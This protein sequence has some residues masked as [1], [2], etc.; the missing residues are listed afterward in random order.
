VERRREIG[1]RVARVVP[2]PVAQGAPDW[3]YAAPEGALDRP[4]HDPVELHG[5]LV[6]GD[7]TFGAD[8]PADPAGRTRWSP[9][10]WFVSRTG[11]WLPAAQHEPG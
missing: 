8:E 9:Q 10:T 6:A 4:C 11:G 5:V 1:A 3:V 7:A 2:A